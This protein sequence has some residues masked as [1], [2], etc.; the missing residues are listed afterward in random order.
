MLYL[1]FSLIIIIAIILYGYWKK[2]NLNS[3]KLNEKAS[4]NN[5]RAKSR[6]KNSDTENAIQDLTI[7]V[8]LE[9][10]AEFYFD[11]AELRYSNGDYST[12][13]EDYTKAIEYKENLKYFKRR[14][15]SKLLDDDIKGAL[16]DISKVIEIEPSGENYIY[17]AGIWYDLM[18]FENGLKDSLKAIECEKKAEYYSYSGTFRRDLFD[19]SGAIEDYSK[20]IELDYNAGDLAHRAESKHRLHDIS[21]AIDDYT[22]S[23]QIQPKAENYYARGLC[24]K[25]LGKSDLVFADFN[26]VKEI[27]FPKYFW[28]REKTMEDIEDF[29]NLYKPNHNDSVAK[30]KY[31]SA[32]KITH[33]KKNRINYL[34]LYHPKWNGTNPKFDD[35]SQSI[36]DLKVKDEESIQYFYQRCVKWLDIDFDAIVIVPSHNPLTS[37]SGIEFLATKI[38]RNKNWID[39]TQCLARTH[40]I[41]KLSYGGDRSIEIHLNSITVEQ[42]PLIREKKIILIDDVTTSGNS[43]KAS[44]LKLEQAGVKEVYMCALGKTA[45][46]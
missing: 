28:R 25:E 43:L 40:E 6:I 34:G 20:A 16:N 5:L 24:Y 10:Q 36:L 44:K 37:N 30:K 22:K 39:A 41:E 27:G 31:V 21:G 3:H 33:L 18:E 35:Y 15:S 11:R 14:C 13:I 4:I 9:T 32:P 45:K 26:R 12:A 38:A 23:I 17:R 1:L 46:Y 19:Y 8:N 29:L 2:K 7:P 42:I